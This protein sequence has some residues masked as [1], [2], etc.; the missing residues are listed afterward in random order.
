MARV[1]KSVNN[2]RTEKKYCIMQAPHVDYVKL[3]WTGNT[4]E[5]FSTKEIYFCFPRRKKFVAAS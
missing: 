4:A 1:F 5:I 2:T 3:S